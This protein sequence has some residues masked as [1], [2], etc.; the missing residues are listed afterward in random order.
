MISLKVESTAFLLVCFACLKQGTCKTRKNLFY[1]FPEALF[2]LE[3]I[4]FLLFKYSNVM[5][6]WNAE[7]WNTK[8]CYWITWEVNTVWYWNLV[9]LCNITKEYFLWKNFMKNFEE[10]SVKRTLR[11]SVCW[12]GQIII[13]LLIHI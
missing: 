10:S 9:S 8:Q 5:P 12:F 7:A 4:Q 13:I 2:V 6:S 1:F 3:I 11:R